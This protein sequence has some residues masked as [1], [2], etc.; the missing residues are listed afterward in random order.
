[1]TNNSMQDPVAY[2]FHY[3]QQEDAL[4]APPPT[5]SSSYHRPLHAHTYA[6]I[7]GRTA[8]T[9]RKK[10][11]GLSLQ[12]SSSNETQQ[13]KTGPGVVGDSTGSDDAWLGALSTGL[14]SRS[15]GDGGAALDDSGSALD[16]G[17][18]VLGDG[19]AALDDGGAAL[20][21]SRASLGQGRGSLGQSRGGRGRG[22]WQGRGGL[23]DGLAGSVGDAYAGEIPW[24][25]FSFILFSTDTV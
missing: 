14:R 2:T 3:H 22:R 6:S 18:A 17:G 13:A 5:L 12:Q 25:V 1:M 15:R 8:Q 9:K 11:E 16:D 10:G 20:N 4:C 24:L 7:I 23:G 21:D 19:G